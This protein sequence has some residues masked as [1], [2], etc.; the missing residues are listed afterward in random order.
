[1]TEADE[2][3]RAAAAYRERDAAPKTTLYSWDSPAYVLFMQRLERELLSALTVARVD[4][5]ST[6]V[7]D[8][9]CGFGY[10]LNRLVDYGACAASGI[11]LME[12]RIAAARHRFP[13]LDLHAGSATELPFTDGSFDL[14]TQFTCL[15]S[16]MDAGV[17]ASI[18]AEMWR[19]VRPG[20]VVLSFDMA[21]VAPA[22]RRVAAIARRLRPGLAVGVTQ[23]EPLPPAELARLFPGE[24]LVRR[25]PTLD[26][27]LT[28][29]IA[30]RPLLTE[31][32]SLVPSLRTHL[33]MVI[34]KP[35]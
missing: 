31:L 22:A 27:G 6:R 1:M 34:R 14:V 25:V 35:S 8:V 4:L 26:F 32:L 11:D 23:V 19:V 2:L 15:S 16:C 20:G 21:P 17:R 13:A 7:L 12:D 30:G 9:G 33:L 3:A 24:V 28:Q 18:A 29:R 5:P 10:F